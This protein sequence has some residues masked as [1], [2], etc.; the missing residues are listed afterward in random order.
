[1]ERFVFVIGAGVF[2]LLAAR[3]YDLCSRWNRRR[4][5]RGARDCL[6]AVH[7]TLAELAECKSSGSKSSRIT[8]S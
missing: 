2:L 1:M 8:H 7:N 5:A 3:A 6:D 4:R